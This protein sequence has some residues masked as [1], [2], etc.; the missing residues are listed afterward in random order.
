MTESQSRT[1]PPESTR[2]RRRRSFWRVIFTLLLLAIGAG[3][4]Y[5]Y[6]TY[7]LNPLQVVKLLPR[8][9]GVITHRLMHP[10]APPFGGRDHVNILVLGADVSFDKSG[11]ARTD[12]IKLVSVDLKK[13][14]IAVL[15]IPR[16][17]W[18]EIPGH[19]DG[20][21]NGAYQLGGAKEADRLALATETVTDLLNTVSG[22]EIHIDHYVRIQTGGF[23][24]IID[25]LGGVELNVEKQMDYDDPS[26][27]LHIHL[28]PGLQR[29][30]GYNAM[31]YARFRHDAESDYGRIRRQDQLMRALAKQ[32]SSP[33][34]DKKLT[35]QIG[36]L[37]EMLKTDIAD[38]DLLALKHLGDQL[39]IDNVYATTLPTVPTHKGLADVVEVQDPVAAA[40]TVKEVLHGPRPTVVV[41]NGSGQ[42]GLANDV[43]DQVD[44]ETYNIL[45]VGTTLQPA[46][47]SMIIALPSQR[48]QALALA[49]TLGIELVDM[50]NPAPPA[51][52]GKKVATPPVAQ[53]T[54]VLGEDYSRAMAASG[55]ATTTQ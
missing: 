54:I 30:D 50:K 3:F 46:K 43:R 6:F 34:A 13:P 41:L 12:T 47:Q 39:G 38:T 44:V 2:N 4:T 40:R 20:R 1:T 35:R 33:D 26:Q 19:K 22:E 51:D 37:V 53:I 16:D 15:S 21:I 10:N 11:T 14:S 5:V 32:L 49:A 7:G 29:L 8:I 24:K 23:I 25:A 31:C 9:G 17:T 18:V 42:S 52:Y 48:Q 55:R 36:V 28:Q 45:A 27:D